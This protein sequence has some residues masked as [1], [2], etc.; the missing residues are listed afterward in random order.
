MYKN[1]I[2]IDLQLL[3]KAKKN[4]ITCI[5]NNNGK[6]V[7]ENKNFMFNI[8]MLYYILGEFKMHNLDTT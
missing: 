2:Q 8:E 7:K 4:C 3:K 6:Y 5:K 1:D